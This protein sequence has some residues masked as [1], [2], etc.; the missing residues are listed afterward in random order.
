MT[1]TLL[2]AFTKRLKAFCDSR[3]VTCGRWSD[4]SRSNANVLA[5]GTK[6]DVPL[7]QV[8]D[9]SPLGSGASL[10][11]ASPNSTGRARHG[12]RCSSWVLLQPAMSLRRRRSHL[13][14]HPWH[15]YSLPTATTR[16]MSSANSAASPASSLLRV[17]FR[18]LCHR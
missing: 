4:A 12:T 6:R 2:A 11:T 16:S 3:G 15:G 9:Q 1:T 13:E 14:S 17:S 10:R 7:H 5:I 18:W 8:Q